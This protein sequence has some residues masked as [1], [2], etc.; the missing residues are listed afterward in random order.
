MESV[1]KRISDG[2]REAEQSGGD[3]VSLSW[4]AYLGEELRVARERRGWS[5]RQLAAHT[6]YS[7]QQISN[8]EAGRRTPSGAFVREVDAALETGGRFERLLRRV[9]TES[10]PLW[11]QGATREEAKAIR[12][13]TYQPQVVHG[14]LQTEA[15]A[16]ALLRSDPPRSSSEGTEALLAARLARQTILRRKVPPYFWL[17]MDE[18]VLHLAVGGREVMAEQL[19]RLLAEEENPNIMIQVLPFSAGA[20][21]GTNGPFILWSYEDRSDVLYVEG[22]LTATIV[23]NAADLESA[24]LSYDLLQAAALPREQSFDMIRDALKGY[25]T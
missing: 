4:L 8:V 3:L 18:S 21:P 25:T 5:L 9:L 10:L 16:R 1:E 7:Y 19:E 12:I 24:R 13:R 14:L 22:L 23:E 2:A 17:I 15:Y 20:H 6:S 11:F